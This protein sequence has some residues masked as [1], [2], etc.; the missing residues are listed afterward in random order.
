[1]LMHPQTCVSVTI[2]RPTHNGTINNKLINIA[3]FPFSRAF[4][5]CFMKSLSKKVTSCLCKRILKPSPVALK[6]RCKSTKCDQY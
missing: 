4:E 1:M 5:A 3:L 2:K 6:A